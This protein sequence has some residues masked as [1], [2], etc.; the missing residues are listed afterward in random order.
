MRIILLAHTP[1]PERAIATAARLCYSPSGAVELAEKMTDAEV[2]K[3]IKFI[4][5]SGHH[6]TIEHA[7]FT[8]AIEAISLISH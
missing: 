6:S 7:S 4:V 1:D 3:L 5:A 2:K 8:F